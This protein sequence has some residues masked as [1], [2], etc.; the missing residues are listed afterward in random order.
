V[1]DERQQVI[2]VDGGVTEPLTVPVPV[3][4]QAATADLQHRAGL[5]L[6]CERVDPDLPGHRRRVVEGVVEAAR[7]N[8]RRSM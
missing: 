8:E 7:F 2:A 1:R 6:R 3:R 4:V 5:A